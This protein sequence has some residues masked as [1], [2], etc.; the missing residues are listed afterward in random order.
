LL[1]TSEYIPG[2]ELPQPK[3]LPEKLPKYMRKIGD[4]SKYAYPFSEALWQKKD[5]EPCDEL[6]KIQKK[7]LMFTVG[8]DVKS[9]PKDKPNGDIKL[10]AEILVGKSREEIELILSEWRYK[11]NESKE[12]EESEQKETEKSIEGSTTVGPEKVKKEVR[13]PV[14]RY[15]LK[16]EP[17]SFIKSIHAITKET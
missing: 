1:H 5:M 13:K 4:E 7:A 2:G 10:D 9:L 11:L 15:G 3:P 8:I 16:K 6:G 12:Q 17:V 14:R